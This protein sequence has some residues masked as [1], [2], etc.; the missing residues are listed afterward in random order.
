[1]FLSKNVSM[2]W[3]NIRNKGNVTLGTFLNFS[4]VSISL[5]TKEK[6]MKMVL[7]NI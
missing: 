7:R 2:F 4:Y 5:Q 1:M 6:P 3:R